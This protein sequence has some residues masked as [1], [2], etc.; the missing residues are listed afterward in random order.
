LS[1]RR[2]VA[3]NSIERTN[4]RWILPR[5]S[6]FATFAALAAPVPSALSQREDQPAFFCLC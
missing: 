5:H 2:R 6:T 3:P 1:L 4:T